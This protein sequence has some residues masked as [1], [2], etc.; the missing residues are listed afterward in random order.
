MRSPFLLAAACGLAFAAMA[1]T[2]AL[3][4]TEARFAAPA[5]AADLNL[6]AAAGADALLNRIESAA[7]EGC[8]HSYG[9]ME[10]REYFVRRQCVRGAMDR[11]VTRLGNRLV[12]QRY[13]ER[14]GR[15]GSVVIAAS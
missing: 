10:L 13:I 14:G 12:T 2:P 5:S 7:R 6:G 11:A 3:A 15:P 9:R 1:A 8:G 4:R